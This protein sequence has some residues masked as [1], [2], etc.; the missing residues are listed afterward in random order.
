M[1]TAMINTE[2]LLT[3]S[4]TAAVICIV[5][6]PSVMFIVGRALSV[7]RPAALAAA[8]GNTL[9]GMAQGVVAALGLGTI[10]SGSP[11]AYN[12]LK[13]GGALYLVAMGA[14]TLRHRGL[15][16]DGAGAECGPGG[17]RGE[18]RQ[19]FWVGATNPKTLVFFAA[20]LPQFV[21]PSR[22]HV[23]T[24]MLVLLTVFS[25]LSL[26]SDS[27]WGFAGGSL[28]RLLAT[29]PRRLELFIG[30]GGISIIAL[31]LMLALSH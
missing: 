19:G 12:A 29:S 15:S 1:N 3:F 21:D 14:R 27:S 28:R 22:G 4:M 10:I 25:V 31:G 2:L 30:A 9:G 16:A 5:P 18:A 20:A 13:L 8:V 7:G 26:I 11:I 6:G 17:K 24:Q 23:I